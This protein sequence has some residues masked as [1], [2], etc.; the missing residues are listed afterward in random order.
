MKAD[1]AAHA[2]GT[3]APRYWTGKPEPSRWMPAYSS[4]SWFSRKCPAA[5]LMSR[6]ISAASRSKP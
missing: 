3:F 5:R 1:P 4:G 2:C 6:A